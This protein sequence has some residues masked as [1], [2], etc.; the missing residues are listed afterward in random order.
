MHGVNVKL[1]PGLP[2]QSRIQQEE[3]PLHQ[4]IWHKYKEQIGE[5][6]HLEHSI[7]WYL[8]MWESRSEILEKF[9]NVVCRR[10]EEISWTDR[11]RNEV[12]NRMKEER[13]ILHTIMRRMANWIDYVSSKTH[14][15]QKDRKRDISDGRQ[16]RRSQQLLGNLKGKIRHWKLK[17]EAGYFILWRILSGI[18]YA[19]VARH[20]TEW[21][22]DQI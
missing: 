9:W 5:M 8:D 4:Q 22:H 6:L 19:P 3:D 13:N 17:E 16:G 21:L 20:A 18:G 2:K 14:Y 10:M 1:N 11:V 12:S 7:V 15:W